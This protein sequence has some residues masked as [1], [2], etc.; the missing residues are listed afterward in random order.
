V[1]A[2]AARV[3]RDREQNDDQ[4]RESAGNGAADQQRLGICGDATSGRPGASR[5]RCGPAGLVVLVEEG[6][7]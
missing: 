3:D 5:P 1:R 7:G 2:A 4:Q 6:Q